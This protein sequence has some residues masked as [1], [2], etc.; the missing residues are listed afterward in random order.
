MIVVDARTPPEY[1]SRVRSSASGENSSN[2][3]SHPVNRPV[4]NG[5]MFTGPV[6]NGAASS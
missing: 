6:A 3:W 1:H 4:T 5:V 2:V